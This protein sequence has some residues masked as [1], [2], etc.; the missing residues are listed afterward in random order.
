[1]KNL[2][3]IVTTVICLGGIA[4]IIYKNKS[5]TPTMSEQY[6]EIKEINGGN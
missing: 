6:V 2:F 4:Y 3:K 1:M 5:N